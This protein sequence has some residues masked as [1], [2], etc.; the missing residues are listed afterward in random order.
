MVMCPCVHCGGGVKVDVSA[1]VRNTFVP[2]ID[3]ELEFEAKVAED[4]AVAAA[5]ACV[6]VAAPLDA[7]APGVAICRQ[8]NQFWGNHGKLKQTTSPCSQG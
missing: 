7:A 5:A 8:V 6:D 2:A 3:V 4:D 1:G